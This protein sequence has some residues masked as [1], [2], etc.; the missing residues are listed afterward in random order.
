MDENN[1]IK[2]I[3]LTKGNQQFIIDERSF[4]RDSLSGHMAREESVEVC[5]DGN[6]DLNRIA[7]KGVD[8]DAIDKSFDD[9][10]KKQKV[11]YETFYN[12]TN[13]YYIALINELKKSGNLPENSGADLLKESTVEEGGSMSNDLSKDAD[14][15]L[16]NEKKRRAIDEKA[17]YICFEPPKDEVGAKAQNFFK[18]AI[19][20]L[21]D[22]FDIAACIEI[23]EKEIREAAE[24]F[25][26][27]IQSLP[28]GAV[29]RKTDKK[30][31]VLIKIP[32]DDNK[33]DSE[34]KNKKN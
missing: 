24:E 27:N 18:N 22:K 6:I 32:D 31:E 8:F 14:K 21:Q 5:G 13:D 33:N 19:K 11:A 10:Y 3:I 16:I 12:A 15:V 17:A 20:E 25:Y 4:S 28:A 26:N 9:F 2:K 29:S 30:I 34:N 7:Q 1:K 23:R